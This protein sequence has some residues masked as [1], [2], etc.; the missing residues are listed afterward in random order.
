MKIEILQNS[1]ESFYHAINDA[2][3][4]ADTIY[5]G[6]AYASY[7]AF[8]LFKNQ[9][10]LFL[11]KN[12]KLRA[13]FDI[14]EFI[15]EK[16]LIEEFA[17]IPG[18]SECKVFIKSKTRDQG[19]Q[20]NYHPKFYLFFNND[21]Y[22]VI[23]GSSNFTFGG[24]KKNIECNLSIS[25]QKNSF[26]LDVS[27]YFD[28]LW[29]SEYSINILNHGELLD[30]YQNVFIKN[31]KA[32]ESK[33]KKLSKLRKKIEIHADAIIKTKQEVLN[34]EF[35]YLLGLMSANSKLNLRNRVLTIDLFRGL[36]NRGKNYE[37]FYYN[38]DISDYKISQYEAHKK[39]V[40]RIVENLS[41]LI[42]H[43][44][45]KDTLSKNH[46]SGYHFQIE[47]EFD[48]ASVIYKKIINLDVPVS[49]GKVVSFVPQDIL[50]SRDAKIIT[51][52]IKGYCDLKSRISISD[53]IYDKK[54]GVYSL[55]RMGI[56][57]PHGDVELLNKFQNLLK[58][59]GLEKGVSVTDPLKRSRENLIRIDV[60]YVPY[61][62]I[63]THWRRIFLSDF[64]NYMKSKSKK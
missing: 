56:S 6:V 17:T 40:D 46:I 47:I 4:W 2:L 25:S 20:G 38:P 30:A 62:I 39:D 57:M 8:E 61:E 11:R 33:N 59:I 63:G 26:F 49:R 16:K 21:S 24:I 36:A 48:K 64:I 10:E 23:I 22:C 54:Q 18:D 37:G 28:E 52:F 31:V 9:F 34:E 35:A 29:S 44:N 53:G 45:T 12:G 7:R 42:K 55:L 51:S 19:L 13:L 14:E 1:D 50:E 43:L 41:L 32:T 27:A 60:R 15:T 58:K 5:L 3:G